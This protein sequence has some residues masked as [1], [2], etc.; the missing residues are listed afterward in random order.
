LAQALEPIEVELAPLDPQLVASGAGQDHPGVGAC[1]GTGLELP[2]QRRDV[3]LDRLRR[4]SRRS[5]TPELLD[6]PVARDRLVRPQEQQR[7]QLALQSGADP[8][9]P[10][11]VEH[12][13]GPKDPELHYQILARFRAIT[14]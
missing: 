11:P 1:L 5:V 12:L 6:Q 10:T 13:E 7:Q 3:A 8:H 4:G 9:C 14:E 2:A